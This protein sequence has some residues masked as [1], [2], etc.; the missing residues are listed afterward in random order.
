M[1]WIALIAAVVALVAGRVRGREGASASAG[2]GRVSRVVDGDTIKVRL[3]DGRY[4][5][6]RYI[7]IDTPGVGQ[8]WHAGAVLRQAGEPRNEAWS[9][10]GG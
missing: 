7:G 6:V 3:D 8:A 10:A 9:A 5:R 2:T 1:P 4:E